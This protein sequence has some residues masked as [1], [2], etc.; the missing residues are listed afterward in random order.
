MIWHRSYRAD[1]LARGVADRHYSRQSVG[2]RDF[3][4]PGRCCV[5]YVE[6]SGGAAVWGTSWPLAE[7]TKH[8]W[9]GAWVCSIF[10]N[11]TD[12]LS[13][14]LIRQAVA[15]TR[16]RFGAPPALGM[17]TFVDAAKVASPNPGYCF[18]RAGFVH[19]GYTAGGLRAL[20]L[21]P[22]RMPP[23]AP[24]LSAIGELQLVRA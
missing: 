2:G 5:F 11:E 8:A 12:G 23:A 22:A 15:A 1:P 16:A 9:A 20:Q 13:S 14:E 18:L 6:I 7:Y 17:V 3:M 4:P 10:R 21:T 19:V 24:A